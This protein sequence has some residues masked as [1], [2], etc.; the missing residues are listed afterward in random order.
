MIILMGPKHVGKTSAGRALAALVSGAFTDLD[1]Y[2]EARTG[3]S[4]RTLY[5][6][7]RGR[8]LEAEAQALEKLLAESG[9][10]GEPRIIAAGGG[11][12]D[13]PE[14]LALLEAAGAAALVYLD[15]S[16]E[17]AWKRIAGAAEMEGLPPF[18][19]TAN[20]RETHRVLH[21]RRAAAYRRRA[22]FTLPAEG[23]SPEEIAGEIARNLGLL[24]PGSGRVAGDA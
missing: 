18:L 2:I 13:N 16:A 4:P 15:I 14:A 7:G 19:D 1:G 5:Q 9:R 23:K 10:T 24:L 22:S 11:L 17:T 8:F 3:K 20:P 6:E 21:R 12:I